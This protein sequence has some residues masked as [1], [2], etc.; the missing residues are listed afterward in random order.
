MRITSVFASKDK[1]LTEK[2]QEI[3]DKI[4]KYQQ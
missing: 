1:D 2:K 4:D 3:K